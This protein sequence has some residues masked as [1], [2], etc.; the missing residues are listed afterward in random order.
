MTVNPRSRRRRP[1]ERG[2]V[3]TIVAVMLGGGVLLG[4]A[5]LTVDVGALLLE[6]RQLQNGA[7]AAAMRLAGVCARDV[8]DCDPQMR[9]TELA[10]LASQNASDDHAQLDTRAYPNGQC[11]R[12]P[13]VL[14]SILPGCTSTGDIADLRECTPLPGWVQG[15]AAIP[16]VQTYT[17]TDTG[18]GA[19]RLVPFFA[20]GP[21]TE[22][23]TC[24]RA[25]WGPPDGTGNTFPLAIRACDWDLATANGVDLA[26]SPPY[27]PA[28]SPSESP[29][30]DVPAAL[31]PHVT[32]LIAH[33]PGDLK[34]GCDDSQGA[35]GG[36]GWLADHDEEDNC[37]ATYRASGVVTGE[38]G[39]SP[40]GACRHLMQNW[41]GKE[42]LVPVFTSVSGT[43]TNAHYTLSGVSAFYL[44]GWQDLSLVAP[45]ETYGVY[46]LPS[47]VG[48]TSTPVCDIADDGSSS[49]GTSA[50]CIW[51][52][53]TGPILPVGTVSGLVPFRGPEVVQLIG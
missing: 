29:A 40:R 18:G 8:D 50:S 19:T 1:R 11:G 36:F 33:G 41:V 16:Y 10:A 14:D 43:Q 37:S 13:G 52:W 25:V 7:D 17:L 47:N 20:D 53:F 3:A 6:R 51:G 46:R 22:V 23:S 44:A 28:G 48:V 9:E 5:A 15:N 12:V 2:A 21:G 32:H 26:P 24:A 45:H 35:P 31:L 38:L 39:S 30:A 49:E 4:M 42:I 34:S 27:A